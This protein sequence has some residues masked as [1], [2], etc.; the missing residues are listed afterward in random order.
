MGYPFTETAGD[1]LLIREKYRY[2]EEPAWEAFAKALANSMSGRLALKQYDWSPRPNMAARER[3]G[4]FRRDVVRHD[5]DGKVIF[6]EHRAFQAYA[7]MVWEREVSKLRCRPMA[8]AY[9]YLTGY[10]RWMMSYV[11]SC[12]PERSVLAQDTDGIWTTPA[13]SEVLYRF[14]DPES[15]ESGSLHRDHSTPVGRFFGP[16]HYWWGDMWVLSGH[17]TP[18]IRPGSTLVEIR[19]QTV[20]IEPGG[21][22]PVPLV[23]ER[24]AVREIG[25]IQSD[26]EVDAHGWLL[27]RQLLMM[28]D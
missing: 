22:V 2:Q 16:Q 17:A 27:P 15:R 12:C 26:L 1:M 8:A 14:Q 10:G 23:F 18:Q 20:P 6:E 5:K 7:G 19:E 25:R 9:A 28:M 13:A 3:W 11:R 21:E 24:R 4:S